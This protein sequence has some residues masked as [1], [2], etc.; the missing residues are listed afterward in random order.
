[1]YVLGYWQGKQPYLLGQRIITFVSHT[2]IQKTKNFWSHYSE[3]LN[4]W[5]T[6][7]IYFM[8]FKY[9][10]GKRASPW[11]CLRACTGRTAQHSSPV[12]CEGRSDW[13]QNLDPDGVTVTWDSDGWS[14][15]F[16]GELRKRKIRRR[17]ERG[18]KLAV[19]KEKAPGRGQER[20]R[21]VERAVGNHVGR[22]ATRDVSSHC[23]LCLPTELYKV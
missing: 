23:L 4:I 3:Q 11:L 5:F 16:A 13:S 14:L 10:G 18:E 9:S 1:M 8:M 7:F 15:F 12:C 20:N 6:T 17:Q 19:R 2:H 22:P 21:K